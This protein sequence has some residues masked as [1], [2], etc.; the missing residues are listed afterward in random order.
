MSQLFTHAGREPPPG[1]VRGSAMADVCLDVW[2]DKAVA[3]LHPIKRRPPRRPAARR[4]RGRRAAFMS[5]FYGMLSTTFG[6]PKMIMDVT[7]LLMTSGGDT[8]ARF[9]EILPKR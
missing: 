9:G 6:I 1:I 4:P 5:T 8:L 2:V 3:G 7:C